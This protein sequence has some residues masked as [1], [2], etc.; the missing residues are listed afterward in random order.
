MPQTVAVYPGSFD[1]ITYGHMDI[2]ARGCKLFDRVTVA[3]VNNPSKQYLFSVE[4]RLDMLRN[5]LDGKPNIEFDFF[6]GLL[7]EY[8][9]QKGAN[10]VVRGIRAFTDF[11]FELQMAL[12]NKRLS[13]S[14]ETVFL[15]PREEHLYVSSR[16]VKEIARLGGD[17]GELVHPYVHERLREKFEAR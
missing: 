10:I 11:E 8:V 3:L 13:D 2:I 14:F 1:P 17:V 6:D 9:E 4:Q 5:C 7:V 12:M 15:M 16:L